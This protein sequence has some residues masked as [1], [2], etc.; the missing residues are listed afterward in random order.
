M[1]T[2]PLYQIGQKVNYLPTLTGLD[3]ENK[4]T[5]SG[6]MFKSSDSLYESLGV[7]FKPTWVYFFEENSLTAEEKD[8]K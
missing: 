2:N 5:I 3:K 6:R 7:E 1:T 4:L 8:L